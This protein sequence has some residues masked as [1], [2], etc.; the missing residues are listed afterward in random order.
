MEDIETTEESARDLVR[1]RMLQSMS[2]L[3]ETREV[4]AVYLV[5][6]HIA[7][8]WKQA[9]I[10]VVIQDDPINYAVDQAP[11]ERAARTRK[12]R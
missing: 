4:D 3:F 7:E 12:V 5:E 1:V 2:G 9:N 8:A 6:R 11:V 10:A